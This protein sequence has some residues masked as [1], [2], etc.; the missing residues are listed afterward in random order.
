MGFLEYSAK[1]LRPCGQT[2]RRTSF[3]SLA[4]TPDADATFLERR[5]PL[6]VSD[7]NFVAVHNV[8]GTK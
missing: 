5:P 7:T 8:G 4:A 2:I 6:A 1:I 3:L